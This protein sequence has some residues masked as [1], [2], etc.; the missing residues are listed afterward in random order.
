MICW[1][2]ICSV[3][4]VL[5]SWHCI[6]AK[7]RVLLSITFHS[8]SFNNSFETFKVLQICIVHI[9]ISGLHPR[10]FD[11]NVLYGRTAQGWQFDSVW[12]NLCWC[13]QGLFFFFSL[14]CGNLKEKLMGKLQ[15]RQKVNPPLA[16]SIHYPNWPF[17]VNLTKTRRYSMSNRFCLLQ[18]QL[19][20]LYFEEPCRQD[21]MKTVLIFFF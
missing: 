15:S 19:Y 20:N 11:R 14:Q 5:Q 6:A 16:P 3:I 8:S 12:I 21:S 18:S 10:I 2:I 7:D 13:F 4:F 17:S 9:D 1:W